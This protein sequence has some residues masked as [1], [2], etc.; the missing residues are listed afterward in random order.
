MTTNFYQQQLPCIESSCTENARA[1]GMCIHSI[2]NGKE[3]KAY[4]CHKLLRNQHG[5][6]GKSTKSPTG[7]S[8]SPEK[9]GVVQ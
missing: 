8:L 1:R 5:I 4:I 3:H 9:K 7:A 6:T 2:K